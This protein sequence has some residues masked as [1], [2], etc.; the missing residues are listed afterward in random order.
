LEQRALTK[1]N[2]GL[3]I[4][5]HRTPRPGLLQA[6]YVKCLCL[7]LAG[8]GISYDREDRPASSY[9]C[10]DIP[11]GF[12]ADIVVDRAVIVEMKATRPSRRRTKR[13][14]VTMSGSAACASACY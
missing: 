7:E 6:V 12:R 13:N 14:C 9:N 8:A 4:D 5:V 2:I 10:V 11:L 1:R 3:A